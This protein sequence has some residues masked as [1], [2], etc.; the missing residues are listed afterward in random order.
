MSGKSELIMFN[1]TYPQVVVDSAIFADVYPT[2]SLGESPDNIEFVINGANDYIDLNDMLLYLK[3]CI[4]KHDDSALGATEG[5]TPSNFYMNAL[6][7]DVQLSLNDVVV[8]GDDQMYGYK[9]T[10]D[11]IFN[12][13]DDSKRIQLLPMGYCIDEKHGLHNLSNSSWL[14]RYVWISLI[15]QNT[16][17]R[18]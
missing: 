15:N 18:V 8:E 14:E 3:L 16:F 12:F 10:I 6:F 2:T 7:S 1:Q 9:S 5:L 4:K 13:N 11:S 17:Y